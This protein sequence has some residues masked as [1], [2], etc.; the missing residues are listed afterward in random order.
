MRADFLTKK[1]ETAVFLAVYRTQDSA[2]A[3]SYSAMTRAKDAT[4]LWAFE[5]CPEARP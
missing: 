2:G 1:G 4:L 5:S 3:V